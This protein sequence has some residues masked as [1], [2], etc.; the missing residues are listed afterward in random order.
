MVKSQTFELG[1]NCLPEILAFTL[2][3][4]KGGSTQDS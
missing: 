1:L 4:P 3:H 2:L